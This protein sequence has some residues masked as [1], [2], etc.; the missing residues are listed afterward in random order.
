MRLPAAL[1]QALLERRGRSMFP[2]DEA[3]LVVDTD[4][5]RREAMATM[6]REEG[7]PVT[8]ATEGLTALRLVATRR[9]ALVVAAFDLPG[10]LDGVTTMRQARLRCPGVKFLLVAEPGNWPPRRSRADEMI[11]APFHRWELLG[12]IF[13]L[14]H[15]AAAAEA[16]DLARRCRTASFA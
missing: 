1:L 2:E 7:F 9:F 15:R 12:C 6:L 8:L 13:E 3:I 14:I 5:E 4:G 16:T 11:A 10:T